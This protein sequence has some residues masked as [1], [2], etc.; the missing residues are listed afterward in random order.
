MSSIRL[1]SQDAFRK[2]IA[3]DIRGPCA[4]QVGCNDEIVWCTFVSDH[5][6][7]KNVQHHMCISPCRCEP[8]WGLTYHMPYDSSPDPTPSPTPSTS[9]PCALPGQR[10]WWV[11][12]HPPAASPG[13]SAERFL[14]RRRDRSWRHGR[15]PGEI[16]GETR[17]NHETHGILCVFFCVLLMIL[18]V[19]DYMI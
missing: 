13:A 9:Q 3:L 11:P 18:M 5:N 6:R 2:M 12:G 7:Q 8:S 14:P 1:L 16:M 19:S 10:C 4:D 17:R 15:R